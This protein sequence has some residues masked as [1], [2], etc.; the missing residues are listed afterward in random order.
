MPVGR[1]V[2]IP[3]TGGRKKGSL[4]KTTIAREKRFQNSKV[5][6]LDVMF[7]IMRMPMYGAKTF[8]QKLAVHQ[9]RLKAASDAAPY[10]H[11]RLM[12]MKHSNDPDNP[13]PGSLTGGDDPNLLEAARRIAF[14]MAMGARMAKKQA[15]VIEHE[16]TENGTTDGSVKK[17]K[18]RKT[19]HK[20]RESAGVE[21]TGGAGQDESDSEYPEESG[22]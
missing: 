3:K 7:D 10:I 8:N 14:V 12:S 17:V 13:M 5:Q 18:S 6:P 4:N 11:T 15:Q 20:E 19:G 2:G 22:D 21:S 16:G 9:L 1:P